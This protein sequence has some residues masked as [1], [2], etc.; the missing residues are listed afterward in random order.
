M[1]PTT[2]LGPQETLSCQPF[3]AEEPFPGPGPGLPTPVGEDLVQTRQC[4]MEFE[5]LTLKRTMS[6]LRAVQRRLLRARRGL[7]LP[8]CQGKNSGEPSC[9]HP[10][11]VFIPLALR[12]GYG[13]ILVTR[14]LQLQESEFLEA[15]AASF[16]A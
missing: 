10:E 12:A 15:E 4:P 1:V 5:A 3:Q 13:A 16:N 11:V 7:Q 6:G 2:R 14:L 9:R 8:G